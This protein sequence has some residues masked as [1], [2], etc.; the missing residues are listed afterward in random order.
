MKPSRRRLAPSPPHTPSSRRGFALMM[1]LGALVIIAVLI[2]GSSYIGLQESRL[3]QNQLVQSRAAAVAEYGLNKIQSDWDKTPN[4]SM[5]NGETYSLAYAVSGM[6]A[7]D[8][9]MTRLNDET[10]WIVSEGR[11]SFGDAVSVSRMAVKRVGAILRLRIPTIEANAALTS[12]GT[13]NVTGNAKVLG[14]DANPS[15]WGGEC[16][17]PGAAAP[18]IVVPPGL[19]VNVDGASTVSS[20]T[21]DPVAAD[22]DTYIG[23]GEENWNT[24]TAQANFSVGSAGTT[25]QPNPNPRPVLTADETACNKA[26][27]SNWGEPLRTSGSIALCYNFFPI[28]HVKGNLQL[29][30]G[31]GQGILMI[32]GDLRITGNFEWYGIIIATGSIIN[33][34]GTPKIFGAVMAASNLLDEADE[35]GSSTARGTITYQF[36]RCA[37]TRALRGSAQVVQAKERAWAELY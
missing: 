8:V 4:L 15:S 35:P 28:I 34:A 37:V 9:K 24:L 23:Y 7:C 13:V 32:E 14:D 18:G 1:A 16:A 11:A 33:G 17:A 27:P 12:G 25:Y 36:S 20:W 21:T 6:G 30:H 31:R 5:Q 26:D 19:T 10:F 22:P 3:G 2:A 29:Q